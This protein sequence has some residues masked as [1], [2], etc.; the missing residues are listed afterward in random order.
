MRGVLLTDRCDSAV[1]DELQVE[2]EIL[3]LEQGDDFLQ[4]VALLRAHAQLLALDLCLDALGA[5]V[6]DVLRDLL[7]IVFVDALFEAGIDA[8]FLAR[9][10]GFAVFEGLQ[11]DAALDQLRLEDVEDRL[12]AVLADGLHLDGFSGPGDRGVGAAEIIA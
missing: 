6:S 2:I 3:A 9:R 8:V 11:R 7:R 10:I 5:L 4:V 1:V 12:D